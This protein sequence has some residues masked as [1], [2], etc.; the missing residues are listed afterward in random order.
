MELLL[1]RNDTDDDVLEQ[2]GGIVLYGVSA[3]AKAMAGSTF[4]PR[5]LS[6][7]V[8]SCF[9]PPSSGRINNC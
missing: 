8:A 5:R 1:K 9:N 2:T 3:L 7:I 6:E 4:S